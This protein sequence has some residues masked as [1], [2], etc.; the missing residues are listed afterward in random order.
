MSANIE[1]PSFCGDAHSE[2]GSNRSKGVDSNLK[3]ALEMAQA[4]IPVFPMRIFKA[5]DRWTKKPAIKGWRSKATTDPET[6]EAWARADPARVFGIELDAAGLIV[7]DCDRHRQ[8]ADGC[9]AF[10]QLVEANG[11]IASVPITISSGGGWHVYFRQPTVQI[12]CPVRTGLPPGIDVKGAGGNIVVPGSRRPDGAEWRPS[13]E[14]PTL[15]HAYRNGLAIIPEW[16]EKLARKVERPDPKPERKASRQ[17]SGKREGAYANAAVDRQCRE[18]A[19][20]AANAGRNQK[21]NAAAFGLGRMVARGWI[22][23]AK[24]VDALKEAAA[25]CGLV[26][27]DGVEAVRATIASG[28]EAGLKQPRPDLP[29]KPSRHSA[30]NGSSK[31]PSADPDDE[32]DW[33]AKLQKTDTGKIIPNVNNALLVL[34]NDPDVID[35]FAY[36]QMSRTVMI[37]RA[38]GGNHHERRAATDV[39]ITD[40]QRW[41][42]IDGNVRISKETIGQAM[43]RRAAASSYHP[44]RDHLLSLRWDGKPR[45]QTGLSRY[46]GAE[47]GPYSAGIGMMFMVSMV[48]RIFKPGCK[49]DHMLVLEGGQGTMKSTACRVLAGAAYFSDNLPDLANKDSSQHLRGKWLIEV[50]EMHTFDRAQTALLKSFLTRQEERY[51]PSY[52]RLEVFEQRQCVFIGTTNKETYLHDETGARRFWPVRTGTIDIAALRRDRDQLLAEAVVKYNDGTEWWPDQAFERDHIK[53]QQDDRYEAD[54]W[55]DRVREYV[56]PLVRTTID[57]VA[58]AIGIEAPKIGTSDQRRLASILAILGWKR[59]KREAGTGKRYWV[60]G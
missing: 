53:P 18:I 19:R 49:V 13:D 16:L 25:A 32:V 37:G 28:L 8:D 34:E 4:G 23:S 40:L 36:D 38:I 14:K 24:V 20:L 17:T 47:L 41:L 35:C 29:R 11:G 51:R 42:Q 50:A 10:K 9:S 55:E 52:G 15:A 6:I 31:A 26:K 39:D 27:D 22:D 21:L 44:I 2:T 30:R 57:E 43:E 1:E 54:A 7:I 59:G 60:R 58:R 56:S 46:L 48:A 3:A 45:L 5:G 12:G 33:R